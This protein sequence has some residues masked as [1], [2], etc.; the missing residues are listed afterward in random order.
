MGCLVTEGRHRVD[1]ERFAA[2]SR[3]LNTRLAETGPNAFNRP[4]KMHLGLRQA[5]RTQPEGRM[6]AVESKMFGCGGGIEG[7]LC[8]N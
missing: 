2:R 8:R 5:P 4:R 6:V 7:Q 3:A 1:A